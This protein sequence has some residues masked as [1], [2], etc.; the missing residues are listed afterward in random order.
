MIFK[1]KNWEAE[2][3]KKKYLIQLAGSNFIPYFG[4]IYPLYLTFKL[5]SELHRIYLGRQLFGSIFFDSL[6]IEN[7]NNEQIK[8]LLI[9][10]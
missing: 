8:R 5:I 4:I 2:K 9:K 3:L 10:L 1:R 6:K 7:I